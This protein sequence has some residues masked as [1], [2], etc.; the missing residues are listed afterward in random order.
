MKTLTVL[1][2]DVYLNAN[3]LT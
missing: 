1:I 2:Q 3:D